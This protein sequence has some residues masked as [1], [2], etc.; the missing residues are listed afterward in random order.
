MYRNI[1]ES[2]CRKLIPSDVYVKAQNKR[3]PTSVVVYSCFCGS[4]MANLSD[5]VGVVLAVK[6]V[7]YKKETRMESSFSTT[8]APSR[9]SPIN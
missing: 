6:T 2:S 5:L 4:N 3:K 8:P 7:R 1:E 9:F